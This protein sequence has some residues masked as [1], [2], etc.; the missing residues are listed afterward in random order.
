MGSYSISPPTG[1]TLTRHTTTVQFWC[2]PSG[3]GTR[4]HKLRTQFSM[5]LPY[6]QMPAINLMGSQAV[7]ICR[8]SCHSHR[9]SNCKNNCQNSGKCCTHNYQ[10]VVRIYIGKV[11]KGPRSTSP[12]PISPGVRVHHPP[13]TL[14]YL[15]TKK[16][17]WASVS[18]IF[19]GVLLVC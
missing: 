5:R 16:F 1:L 2:W 12:M 13:G 11:W 19:L 3:V 4:S 18:R 14:M 6:F 17:P 10:F 9:F 8:G 7:H 15:P